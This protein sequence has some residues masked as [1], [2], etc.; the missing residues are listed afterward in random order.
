VVLGAPGPVWTGA[1]VAPGAS[2]EGTIDNPHARK[3]LLFVGTRGSA[4]ALS[5]EFRALPGGTVF[6]TP[7]ALLMGGQV[8][9][10]DPEAT[11]NLNPSA[12]MPGALEV[13]AVDPPPTA[14]GVRVSGSV[15]AV[16]VTVLEVLGD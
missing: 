2:A 5:L 3:L 4:G 1:P 8:F 10:G 11:P 6:C 13:C 16:T 9:I 12:G 14:I 15:D 7:G